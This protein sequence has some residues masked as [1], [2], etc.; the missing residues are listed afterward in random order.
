MT[1]GGNWEKRRAGTLGRLG[2]ID[3]RRF[4][5]L[6]GMSAAALVAGSAP[7]TERALARPGFGGDP[8]RLGVAS[9][10]PLADGVVLWTR[11]APEPLAED[12]SG[13]MPNGKVSVRW[14]VAKD[15]G[16]RSVVRRG[17]EFARLE[18]AHSV[19]VEVEGLEPAREYF[20]RFKAGPEI[21]PVG[22]TKT[23]P[24]PGAKVSELAFAFASCQ[25][26][27]HGYFTAYGHMAEED[28]DLVVHLGDY[29]YEYGKNE[30][31]APGGNVREH[32]PGTEITT[33]SDY[34]IRHGQYRKAVNLRRAHAAFPWVVTW[35]D[36][37][38]E[39]NYADEVS[40]EDSE[41]DQDP[42]VFLKRRAA[43]YQAY[44]EHMPLR[45][46]SVPKGPDMRIYRRLA[47]GNLAEFNVL[48]TRQYRDDQP[49]DDAYPGDCAERFDADRTILG[50]RQERWLL[51]GLGRSR[52]R[53]N[54]L[55][56]QIFLAQIDLVGGPEE[57][58]YVDGWDGY[59]ASRDRLLGFL[60]QQEVPNPVVLTGDW[61]ANW[62]CDLKTD[63]DDPESPTVGAEFVGT[64]ITSTDVLG[65]RPA[66]GRVV[67]EENP[68]IR[69]FNNERG[70]VRC[71]LT[72]EEWRT[73]YRV[74]PY[75]KRPGAP[76]R[77]R[78]SFVLED[79]NP[80]A[81]RVGGDPYPSAT[82][83]PPTGETQEADA[84]AR[85]PDQP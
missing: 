65:A 70:Y 15:E 4:I 29:I 53:W 59:V 12:G 41:P 57:G 63:F 80:V 60:H 45:R 51:N 17:T 37:E 9:G 44:Y 34:R 83:T 26:Y 72:P 30:Y 22:R 84:R 2:E 6:G 25:Q 8:F 46:S 38:V 55:A 36:H 71:R 56:Q 39:N 20:Y 62:L 58:F 69:F 23:T 47:Y 27:E 42:E 24:A 28:L 19:H 18:L 21:S 31:V 14:E 66:Y 52:A 67:L 43:A 32:I 33:L 77:T 50:K 16:F 73:D 78:A 1:V 54:V 35:D 11:L 13:G 5:A 64:S 82:R 3:R 75:V 40:E 61:H 48:D 7:F 68:H 79:G 74:V 81:Q 10:D 85:I 76:V 49:C